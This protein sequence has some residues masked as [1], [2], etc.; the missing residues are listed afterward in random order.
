MSFRYSETYEASDGGWTLVEYVYL[1]AWQTGLGQREYHWHPLGGADEAVLHA[2]CV[3]AGS[4]DRGHY[5][6]YRVLL[7]EARDEFLRL[8]AAGEPVDCRDL[9]P[10]SQSRV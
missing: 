6:S 2:H 9:H 1:M 4:S 7:E 10:F 5:R 3:G 8:Y